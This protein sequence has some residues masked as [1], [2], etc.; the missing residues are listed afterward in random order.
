MTTSS[1]SDRQCDH[2]T[3]LGATMR[4][5]LNQ[6]RHW[7]DDDLPLS[8]DELAAAEALDA[9]WDRFVGG[10]TSAATIQA[11]PEPDPALT[12]LHRS[13][14]SDPTRARRIW[15]EAQRR[16]RA[17]RRHSTALG[18]IPLPMTPRDVLVAAALLIMVLTGAVGGWDLPGSDSL[19]LSTASAEAAPKEPTATVTATNTV[20]ATPTLVRGTA[21]THDRSA[22]TQLMFVSATATPAV[23]LDATPLSASR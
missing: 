15:D 23:P 12:L 20:T 9:D 17:A 14:A 6:H 22:A 5:P 21:S 10:A 2:V 13:L 8:P 11:P 4:D 3:R 7:T 19:G 18:I 16:A 1:T